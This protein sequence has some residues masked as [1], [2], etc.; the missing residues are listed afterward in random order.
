VAVVG[1]DSGVGITR[2]EAEAVYKTFASAL[3][4]LLSDSLSANAR[5]KLGTVLPTDLPATGSGGGT[6]NPAAATGTAGGAG[7]SPLGGATLGQPLV[8]ALEK[9]VVAQLDGLIPGLSVS[10]FGKPL[11]GQAMGGGNAPITTQVFQ[12]IADRFNAL[13]AQ[14]QAAAAASGSSTGTGAGA[15]AGTGAGTGTG[16]DALTL[17]ALQDQLKRMAQLPPWLQTTIEQATANVGGGASAAATGAAAAG[18]GAP[19]PPTAPPTTPPAPAPAPAAT[20]TGTAA[21]P[22]APA[23][24][25]AVPTGASTAP[26]GGTATLNLFGQSIA[27]P[28]PNLQQQPAGAQAQ[29]PT[30]PPAPP[31]GMP[32]FPP[33]P[34]FP[35]RP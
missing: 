26:G 33:L 30:T 10:S 22:P 31:V 15:G 34:P 35:F 3:N 8:A 12:A 1:A 29:A 19:P 11:T 14:E 16:T 32:T 25:G 13:T 7:G 20:G 27:V 24:P 9:A 28:L 18:G 21:P 4:R 23:A 2:P 17:A 5:A 6:V